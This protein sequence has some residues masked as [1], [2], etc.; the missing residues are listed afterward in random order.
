MSACGA[1]RRACGRRLHCTAGVEGC[2]CLSALIF[3]LSRQ[4][5]QTHFMQV[6]G[7]LESVPPPPCGVPLAHARLRPQENL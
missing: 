2:V 3:R 6:L 1:W 4:V 5:I 7:I